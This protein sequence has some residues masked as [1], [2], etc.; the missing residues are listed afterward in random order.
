M[1]CFCVITNP[2]WETAGLITIDPKND[3]FMEK[4]GLTTQKTKDRPLAVSFLTSTTK[5]KPFKKVFVKKERKTW[6]VTNTLCVFLTST[7]YQFLLQTQH[8]LTISFGCASM[9]KR[10]LTP[11][12]KCGKYIGISPKSLNPKSMFYFRIILMGKT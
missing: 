4:Y 6:C 10:Y 2:A 8:V 7:I 5:K 11:I 12:Q 9:E 3:N 1:W